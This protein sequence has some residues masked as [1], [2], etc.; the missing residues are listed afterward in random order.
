MDLNR[1]NN[2]ANNKNRKFIFT[3]YKNEKY[4]KSFERKS[5]I[6]VIDAPL[7]IGAAAKSAV[8]IF[9]KSFGNLKKNTIV[10]IQEYNNYNEP[11]GE[12][13]VPEMETGILPIKK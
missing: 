5:E 10:S 7:D 6:V 12:P 1:V 3:W 9:T 4:N 2:Q 8:N 13:I 11:I